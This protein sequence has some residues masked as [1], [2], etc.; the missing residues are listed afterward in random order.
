MPVH[1]R[2]P[3]QSRMLV[4]GPFS[5]EQQIIPGALVSQLLLQHCDELVHT[6]PN[7]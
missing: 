6:V 2:D 4:H 3:Q 1:E 7:P 5:S